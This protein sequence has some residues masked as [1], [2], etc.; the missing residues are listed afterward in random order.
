MPS[1]VA[2]VICAAVFIVALEQS[3]RE[4][5]IPLTWRQRLVLYPFCLVC[6]WSM[7]W[8]GKYTI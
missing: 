3:F 4:D 5:G 1:T 2:S 8:F 6:F 7:F